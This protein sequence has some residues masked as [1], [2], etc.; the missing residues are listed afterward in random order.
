[1]FTTVIPEAM[2]LLG[3]RK[4]FGGSY[5]NE[6]GKTFIVVSSWHGAAIAI[7]KYGHLCLAILCYCV[8]ASLFFIIELFCA[9]NLP[10]FA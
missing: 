5:K 7:K 9:K 10:F 8:I 4:K 6:R 3:T 1:M 2:M